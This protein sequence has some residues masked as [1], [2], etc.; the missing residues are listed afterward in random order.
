MVNFDYD[1]KEWA[2]LDIL[3]SGLN[4]STLIPLTNSLERA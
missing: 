4:N 1:P 3:L 2:S